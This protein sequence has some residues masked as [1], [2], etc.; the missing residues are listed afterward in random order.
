MINF[1]WKFLFLKVMSLFLNG[2]SIPASILGATSLFL[3]LT[4]THFWYGI[5]RYPSIWN[6]YV[7]SDLVG[8]RLDKNFAEIRDICG[9]YHNGH[10]R[11]DSQ[12]AAFLIT[13]P[14]TFLYHINGFGM[15][16]IFRTF[17]VSPSPDEV[18]GT[19]IPQSISVSVHV[20]NIIMVLLWFLG[21][22]VGVALATATTIFNQKFYN[23][24]FFR[25]SFK[26]FLLSFVFGNVLVIQDKDNSSVRSRKNSRRAI[27]GAS[28][29]G[30]VA[31]SRGNGLE[32]LKSSNEKETSSQRTLTKSNMF[33][34]KW[35]P[36]KSRSVDDSARSDGKTSSTDISDVLNN[37]RR[38]TDEASSSTS[39]MKNDSSHRLSTFSRSTP[40]G[41]NS[42]VA[43]PDEDVVGNELCNEAVNRDDKS[44]ELASFRSAEDSCSHRGLQHIATVFASDIEKS[45]RTVA[46]PTDL[47]ASDDP[48]ITKQMDDGAS[49]QEDEDD[50]KCSANFLN[51]F[52]VH[53]DIENHPGTI[54]WRNC[55]SDAVE[56]FPIKAYTFRKHNWIM[57]KMHGRQFFVKENGNP[58]RKLNR[59]EI[60]KRCKIVHEK[61]LDLRKQI[62]GILTDLK[63]LKKN[64]NSSKSN[65]DHSRNS[66]KSV[67]PMENHEKPLAILSQHSSVDEEQKRL[68]KQKLDAA[69]AAKDSQVESS[70]ESTIS[71]LTQS[72]P[73]RSVE[74]RSTPW[75]QGAADDV[76]KDVKTTGA[77]ENNS[78]HMN[79]VINDILNYTSWLEN[80]NPLRESVGNQLE[81]HKK[82]G[83]MSAG[84]RQNVEELRDQT[85]PEKQVYEVA[86]GGIELVKDMPYW[87]T[88][89]EDI[90][91]KRTKAMRAPTPPQ[92]GHVVASQEPP[93][94]IH[95]DI[96][97]RQFIDTADVKTRERRKVFPLWRLAIRNKKVN[98]KKKKSRDT[99]TNKKPVGNFVEASSPTTTKERSRNGVSFWRKKKALDIAVIVSDDG[100]VDSSP[101]A[102]GGLIHQLKHGKTMNQRL[103][104]T[105]SIVDERDEWVDGHRRVCT[106]PTRGRIPSPKRSPTQYNLDGGNNNGE[107]PRQAPPNTTLPGSQRIPSYD[108]IFKTME[109]KYLKNWKSE[110]TSS[111][112]SCS[113]SGASTMYDTVDSHANSLCYDTKDKPLSGRGGGGNS[114][115]DR[116]CT[117]PN[118]GMECGAL[119]GINAVCALPRGEV[120]MSFPEEEVSVPSKDFQNTNSRRTRVFNE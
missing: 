2:F 72:N 39:E 19:N 77:T 50:D 8:S 11:S 34:D 97:N 101:P 20:T 117:P 119:D 46:E 95:W 58:R 57:K 70:K 30:L 9:C 80:L 54:A 73:P 17:G 42:I 88:F 102:D 109:E 92:T 113:E 7:S 29:F 94:T 78:D 6:N 111:E 76:V 49:Q 35:V 100:Y 33:K 4:I 56:K 31:E 69:S 62:A 112:N 106:S 3:S 26:D 86:N 28:G 74:A 96:E 118:C 18:D 52:D 27:I 13:L 64:H 37:L 91:K 103:H 38:G 116:R 41:D 12:L 81:K 115:L 40:S 89:V 24:L 44:S 65:S 15:T 25:R 83:D 75:I 61:Q 21:G 87:R 32:A 53:I 98:D 14:F 63:D 23:S 55:V 85:L 99:T 71:T 105:N 104:V 107:T 66:K 16:L 22:N 114:L 36:S 79:R 90:P 59:P 93:K 47:N 1:P 10:N 110:A 60:K 67:I 108:Q 5:S 43:S 45:E 82:E 68:E 51:P 84:G 48:I 120:G